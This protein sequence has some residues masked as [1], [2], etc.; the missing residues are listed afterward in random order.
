M[1][2]IKIVLLFFLILFSAFAR[3]D[4]YPAVSQ[5]KYCGTYNSLICSTSVSSAQDFCNGSIA[6]VLPS[7]YHISGVQVIGSLSACNVANSSNVIA[8]SVE[9]NVTTVYTCPAG[10]T[11]S[12]STCI[13]VT[14]CLIGQVRNAITEQC[15]TPPPACTAP[16]VYDNL[17]SSCL[18][19]ACPTGQTRLPAPDNTCVTNSTC[20]ATLP[21]CA[22]PGYTCNNGDG[23][24]QNVPVCSNV[25][26]AGFHQV[27]SMCLADK[28]TPIFCPSGFVA[29]GGSCVAADPVA[30][31]AG[32][33]S[34]QVNGATV[35]VSAGSQVPGT[36]QQDHNTATGTGT[37]A[38]TTTTKDAAGNVTGS[39]TSNTTTTQTLDLNTT[40]MA[41]ES[42]LQGILDSIIGNGSPGSWGSSSIAA[43]PSYAD[44]DDQIA[45][46]QSD[47]RSQFNAL[48][49]SLSGLITPL[50]GGGSISCDGG[51]TLS[52]GVHASICFSQYSSLFSKI[53]TVVLFVATVSAVLLVLA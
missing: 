51:F 32:T 53:G 14:A 5:V 42:T 30:C 28:T 19:P 20:P 1:T 23:T 52:N 7:Y 26:P 40:G 29:K 34:G 48:R 36:P 13:N 38:T 24:Q 17:S 37:Q 21:L 18:V 33:R 44:V 15:Q 50:S 16:A 27:G 25:C 3:A 35:C 8:F 39:Q 4:T 49:A 11:V 2:L 46:G 41:R 22:T 47:L 12:G 10:G 31:P 45:A 43:P 6:P 9:V